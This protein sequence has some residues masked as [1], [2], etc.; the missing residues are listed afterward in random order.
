MAADRVSENVSY[1]Y[2]PY[3]P[4]ILRLVNMTIKGAHKNGKWV[5]MRH[6][7]RS[8]VRKISCSFRH[9]RMAR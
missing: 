4:S 1:L 6:R 2:Q 7:A 9:S 8:C 5:G 3:N